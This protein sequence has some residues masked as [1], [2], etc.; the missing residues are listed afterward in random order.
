MHQYTLFFSSFVLLF[1]EIQYNAVRYFMCIPGRRK[2]LFFLGLFFSSQIIYSQTTDTLSLAKQVIVRK[3][4]S[5][6]EKLLESY[7][8]KHPGNLNAQWLYG[9]AAYFAKHFKK[10]QVIYEDAIRWH[11]E[12]YTLRLDYARKLTDIGELEKAIPLLNLYL[13]YDS[14]ASDVHEALAKISFW[15][16][17]YKTA[18]AEVNKVLLKQPDNRAMLSL[19]NE[20]LLAKSPWLKV[21]ATYVTDDQPLQTITPSMEAGLS[22]HPLSNLKFSLQSPVFIQDK[23]FYNAQWFAAGNKMLFSKAG[24]ELTMEGGVIKLPANR[25]SGTLNFQM[26]KTFIKHLVLSV[27]SGY[28]PYLY[29]RSSMEHPVMQA[30]Y[31]LAAAW[32]PQSSWQGRAAFDVN[33]FYADQN[34][35]RA[36]SA[37]LICPSLKVS[38]FTFRLGY[39]YNFST[40]KDSRFVSEKPLKDVISGW[41]T[42]AQIPGIYSPYFTPNEQH[43]HSAILAVNIRP[44]KTVDIGLKGNVCFS[45]SARNPYLYLTKDA[46][47]T[48]IIARNYSDIAIFPAEVSFYLAARLRPKTS[49]KAEYFFLK[50]NFYISHYAGLSLK[51]SFWHEG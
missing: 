37:W 38:A 49:L 41:N 44:A 36:A 14:A 2:L 11:P 17:E 32:N 13:A 48:I 3:Q 47:N 42:G 16:A 5:K 35:L 26:S 18:L 21:S 22:F 50:N 19:K 30:N 28:Q 4:F 45:G 9:Q 23:K 31:S 10:S 20:I 25:V 27:Q 39:G 24:V 15:K 43:T 6:A 51:I 12:N 46:S 34:S 7:C 40:S 29:T 1:R 8:E 33:R